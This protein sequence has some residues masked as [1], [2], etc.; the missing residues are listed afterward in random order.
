MVS[1]KQSLLKTSDSAAHTTCAGVN[2]QLLL[3]AL[4]RLGCEK[5]LFPHPA[6]MGLL[7]TAHYT[8]VE[9]ASSPYFSTTSSRSVSFSAVRKNSFVMRRLYGKRN[10]G[11]LTTHFTRM[12]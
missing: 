5:L 2:P 7:T 3:D 8:I 11:I 9:P 10:A 4:G 1:S 12:F 6:N